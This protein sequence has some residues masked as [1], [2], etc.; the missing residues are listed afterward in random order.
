MGVRSQQPQE[1]PPYAAEL[2]LLGSSLRAHGCLWHSQTDITYSWWLYLLET[3]ESQ[4]HT[5]GSPVRNH[6]APEA[7]L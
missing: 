5:A 7:D 2:R 6:A 3:E 1:V 4:W